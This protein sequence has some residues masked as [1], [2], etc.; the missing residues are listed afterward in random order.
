MKRIV[1]IQSNDGARPYSVNGAMAE[2]GFR[3]MGYAIEYFTCSQMGSLD[4]TERCQVVGGV[5]TIHAA[6]KKLNRPIPDLQSIPDSLYSFLGRK[7]WVESAGELREKAEYP[8]FIKPAH[9][10]KAFTGLVVENEDELDCVFMGKP[11][12][13]EISDDFELMVQEPIEIA[14][15]WRSFVLNGEVIGLGS[16]TGDPLLVPDVVKIDEILASYKE[17]PSAF[18]ADFGV[19]SKGETILVE[20]NDGYSIGH[21]C[22]L[23]FAYA[24]LLRTRWE[25]LMGMEI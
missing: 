5:G 12:F 15:E 8:I 25:E 21:G 2:A 17:A 14:S 6:L 10:A 24:E 9:K 18:A 11:G 23:P 4:L 20:V 19:T 7:C 3:K 1:Y 13:A 16:I 22:L